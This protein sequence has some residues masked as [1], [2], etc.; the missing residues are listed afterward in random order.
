MK[1]KA[2][3]KLLMFAEA[4]MIMMTL[5]RFL[6]ALLGAE[7]LWS[8]TL[9]ALLE[10][11]TTP[12]RD[13]LSVPDHDRD[14]LIKA[15]TNWRNALLHANFE[16]TAKNAGV[17]TTAE[18]FANVFASELETSYR[19]TNWLIG[20]ID[21]ATGRPRETLA[22]RHKAQTGF[23]EVLARRRGWVAFRERWAARRRRK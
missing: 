16:Q 23:L 10:K 19:V 12:K 9:P 7:A 15:V 1:H 2:E 20:Q 6:R 8:D 21:P 22:R 11:A 5:E 13:L 17:A 3:S 14:S 18:Y 4:A